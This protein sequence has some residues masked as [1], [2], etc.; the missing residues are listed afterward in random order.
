MPGMMAPQQ[1]QFNPYTN[2]GELRRGPHSQGRGLALTT[3][4]P[5]GG[6]IMAIAGKDFCVVAGDTRQSEG[7]SIQT[8]YKPRVY[9]LC[10][11]I[12]SS[13]AQELTE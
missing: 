4:L 1:R 2:N 10:V 8:R 13:H 11:G 5:T 12:R 9:R 6:S 7:Y 3:R